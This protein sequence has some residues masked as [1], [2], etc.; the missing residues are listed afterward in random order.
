MPKTIIE[1]FNKLNLGFQKAKV[2]DYL[3]A[4]EKRVADLEAKVEALENAAP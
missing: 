2:G 1:L 4:L 3:A